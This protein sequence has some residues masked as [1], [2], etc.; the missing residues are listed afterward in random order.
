ME[1]K[2]STWYQ[3]IGDKRYPVTIDDV[4]EWAVG[5]IYQIDNHSNFKSYIGKKLLT[6]TRRKKI[7]VRKKLSSK[8]RKTYE[9]TVKDSGW[10]TYNSSSKI[11]QKEIADHPEYF[12]KHIL[13]WAHSKKHL[14]YLEVRE[15]MSKGLLEK[16]SYVDNVAAKWYRRDLVKPIKPT[17]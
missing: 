17:E 4:P 6:S 3:I 10:M 15:Q 5:F 7:G 9:T 1:D 11:L 13:H 14:S 2:V 12:S 16:E 8:T